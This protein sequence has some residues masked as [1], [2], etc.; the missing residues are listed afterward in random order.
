MRIENSYYS[1]GKFQ[2]RTRT[3]FTEDNGLPSTDAFCVKYDTDGTLW[4]GT[5][6]GLAYYDGKKEFKAV[7]L[8]NNE[9]KVQ[10]LYCSK[11]GSLWA[12]SNNSLYIKSGKRTFSKVFEAES[13]IV[14]MAE[15]RGSLFLL[16]EEMLYRKNDDNFTMFKGVE[17]GEAQCIAANDEQLYV[18]TKNALLALSGKRYH[19]KGILPKFSDLPDSVIRAVSF[20]GLGHLWVGTDDGLCIYDNTSYWMTPNN[21]ATLPA[22]AVRDIVSDKTAGRYFA[23]D[24]GV[25]YMKNGSLKYLG[26]R[27][28][29]PSNNVRSVAVSQDDKT[30]WAAT[31]KGISCIT[32]CMM[33]LQDKAEHY[34]RLIEKYHTR[35][36]GY[37]TSRE[38]DRYED[39]DSG[40]VHI[41]DNDGLWTQRYIGALAFKYAVTGDK[42]TLELARKS[43]KAMIYLTKVTGIPGFTAR[44]I[45]RPG[46]KGY[47]NGHHEWHLAPD[48][49]C[50][51]LCETSS[52]E[53]VGHFYGFSLYYDLCANDEEKKEIKEAVC[54]IVDHILTNNY[55]LIDHDGLQT[56]WAVWTPEI[57]N[58][59][60]KLV[61]EKGINSLEMLS[62]LKV[63]YHM[64]GDEKY[65]KVYKDLIKNHHY[66]LNAAKH[67][68]FDGHVTHIDDNL[69]FLSVTT[70]L[71]LEKNE[72]IRSLLMMGLEHHWQ[73]ERI[74][75]FSHWN[76]VYGAFTNRPCDIDLAVQSLREVP[77][78][79]ICYEIINSTRKGLEYDTEQELWGEKPQ[80]KHPLP[81]DERPANK[82][83]GNPFR[84]DGGNGYFV[85]SG[86]LYLLPYWFARYY[87]LIDET[88]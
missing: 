79:L 14:G 35:A 33:S 88:K 24:N 34:Q 8:D 63:A 41:S 86:V 57:L 73:Y 62:F 87:K 46:E 81:Y 38:L 32:Y 60:D 64:S 23:S 61:W 18:A 26:A 29:V 40:S 7:A 6:K 58:H 3:F 56:T 84:V 83:D 45:R 52:D 55:K 30:V 25:I 53:M 54:G 51:W 47:G 36:G 11:D 78:S 59:D 71:R 44:A 65:D 10:M 43:M 42:K 17:G 74:E 31:D 27:R 4:A 49:T 72:E 82:G 50:E 21:T 13:S 12:G 20:D 2:Q 15:H 76:F 75:R 19:W 80:L 28:W 1:S 37:V 85:E 70:L 48:G 68:V 22:E 77:L 9:Q 39:I 69:G 5:A 66:L 67:K 16:S